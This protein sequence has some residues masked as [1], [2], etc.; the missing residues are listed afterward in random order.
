MGLTALTV[1][2]LEGRLGTLHLL[3]NRG[4]GAGVIAR[5]CRLVGIVSVT[6]SRLDFGVFR[7]GHIASTNLKSKA[8]EDPTTSHS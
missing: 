3:P 6:A 1:A 8:K 5:G 7:T 2:A 4:G